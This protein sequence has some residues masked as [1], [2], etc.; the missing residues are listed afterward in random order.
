MNMKELFSINSKPNV[1]F[2]RDFYN[3]FVDWQ[4]HISQIIQM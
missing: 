1:S 4:R 3:F 2:L